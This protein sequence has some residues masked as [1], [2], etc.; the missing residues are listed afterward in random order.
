MRRFSL[1]QLLVFVIAFCVYLVALRNLMAW[2]WVEGGESPIRHTFWQDV[3]THVGAWLTLTVLYCFWRLWFAM[4]VHTVAAGCLA[5]VLC[6]IGVAAVSDGPAVDIRFILG[7]AFLTSV[8][9]TLASFPVAVVTIAFRGLSMSSKQ[10]CPECGGSHI[11]PVVYYRESKPGSKTPD[12][13]GV[14]ARVMAGIAAFGRTAN[15][16]NTHRG[17]MRFHCKKCSHQW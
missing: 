9:G 17:D 2:E 8:F 6:A 13:H 4:L 7:V 5:Y 11:V 16:R 1:G 10:K 14:Y 12:E 15:N 3:V